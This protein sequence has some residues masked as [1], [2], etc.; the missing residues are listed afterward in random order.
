M[1]TGH[2]ILSYLLQKIKKDNGAYS[3]LK[4]KKDLWEFKNINSY[5]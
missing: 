3:Y 1:L 4:Q 2:A 5:W